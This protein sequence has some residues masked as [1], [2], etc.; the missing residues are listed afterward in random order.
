MNFFGEYL[1]NRR[2]EH[3]LPLRKVAAEL[4]SDI[5]ILSKIVRNE[6]SP[7]KDMLPT[8]SKALDLPEKEIQVEFVQSAISSE[9]GE[10]EFLSEDLKN[11]LKKI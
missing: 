6:R 4:D 7:T 2:K 11:V 5:S 10:L 8:F 1:I 3:G 9:F